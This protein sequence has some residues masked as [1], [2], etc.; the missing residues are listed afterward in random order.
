MCERRV[1]SVFIALEY[2]G[3]L[4]FDL[5]KPLDFDPKAS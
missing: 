1:Q 4:T 3:T 5:P 2:G